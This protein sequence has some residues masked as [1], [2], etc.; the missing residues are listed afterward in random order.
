M[1]M[2]RISVILSVFLFIAVVPPVLYPYQADVEDISADRYFQS[3]LD[4]INNAKESI[5]VVM[6]YISWVPFN[7]ESRPHRLVQALIDAHKRGVKVKVILDQTMDVSNQQDEAIE[8]WK[9]MKA[10]NVYVYEL[11]QREGIDVSFDTSGVNTHAK[12]IIVDGETVIL[13]SSNWTE[14][15]LSSN[16][17]S[18]LLVKSKD[19][20]NALLNDFKGLKFQTP[21]IISPG[22]AIKTPFKFLEDPRL[23][24]QV[25]SANDELLLDVYLTLLRYADPNTN[26]VTI[27]YDKI[28]EDLK[29]KQRHN[30]TLI[31]RAFTK[32]KDKYNL[33]D[34]N[35][36][37]IFRRET[38]TLKLIPQPNERFI[39]LPI[40]Y[41]S[42][43]WDKKLSLRAKV[44]YLVSLAYYAISDSKPWFFVSRQ[45]IREKFHLKEWYVSNGMQELRKFNIVDIR[46]SKFEED[47][48]TPRLAN[49]YKVLGLYDPSK[50]DERFKELSARYGE[51]KV[52]MIRGYAKI[53]YKENDPQAIESLLKLLTDYG[54]EAILKA[55][56]VVSKK[57]PD[58]PKRSIAYLEGIIRKSSG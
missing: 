6:Y 16:V 9:L 49:Y 50:V 57:R 14:T 8:D 54:Q 22:S 19:I 35:K 44:L 12:V 25:A 55:V 41:F 7:K 47:P 30:Q 38:V 56:R 37:N 4:V 23:L 26:I 28:I 10:K 1:V 46:Y 39:E 40:I 18:N 42:Y 48:E 17:E 36:K 33:I 5:F 53:V 24:S 34:F 51:A 20:A 21:T 43:D 15:A 31:N 45:Q 58:N 3:T 52:Q 29:L 13:G 27:S 11:L 2:R 32:L